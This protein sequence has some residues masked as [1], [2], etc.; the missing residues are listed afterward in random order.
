M[1][2]VVILAVSLDWS[3]AQAD[4]IGPNSPGLCYSTHLSHEPDE[5]S[6]W[7]VPT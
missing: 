6:H 5:L 1:A 2:N 4:W 7:P 3:A